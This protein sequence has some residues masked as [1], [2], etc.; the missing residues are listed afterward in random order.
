MTTTSTTNQ[1]RHRRWGLKAQNRAKNI[2][3]YS[4]LGSITHKTPT[5]QHF[6]AAGKTQNYNAWNR[7]IWTHDACNSY[8]W[9][10][11]WLTH[12]Y[13]IV[14]FE[15]TYSWG[16]PNN[17]AYACKTLWRAVFKRLLS[18][19]FNCFGGGFVV[20]CVTAIWSK[21]H[22]LS[23]WSRERSPCNVSRRH[24]RAVAMET[25]NPPVLTQETSDYTTLMEI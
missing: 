2:N 25:F 22:S 11:K 20:W 13:R 4:W 12:A 8:A 5:S 19:R 15:Y 23:E 6:V 17:A 9:A 16:A 7:P 3:T 10:V 14:C 24:Q 21:T 18:L 1:R